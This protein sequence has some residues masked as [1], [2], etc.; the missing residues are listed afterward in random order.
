M[1]YKVGEGQ[2]SVDLPTVTE[3]PNCGNTYSD[4]LIK[5]VRSSD[6]DTKAEQLRQIV[7]LESEKTALLIDTSDPTLMGQS[8]TVSV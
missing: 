8:I 2:V 5:E 7:T 4:F 3:S 6:K 1:S